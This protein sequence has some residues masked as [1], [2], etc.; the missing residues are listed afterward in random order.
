[1]L[2]KYNCINLDPINRSHIQPPICFSVTS[3]NLYRSLG[4]STFCHCNKT[5]YHPE[6]PINIGF[7][8]KLSLYRGFAVKISHQKKLTIQFL[9][10]IHPIQTCEKY[11][12]PL[13]IW[14]QYIE[15]FN[16]SHPQRLEIK[17]CK[18][19]N[20]ITARYHQTR[21]KPSLK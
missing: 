20:Q 13:T 18:N 19:L 1:M 2:N 8:V 17:T 6:K 4:L 5:F 16:N 12:N 21:E 14:V 10:L 9:L 11:Y 15:L 7:A 3:Y